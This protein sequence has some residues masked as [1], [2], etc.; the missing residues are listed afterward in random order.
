MLGYVLMQWS[1]VIAYAFHQLWAHECSY[2]THDLDL[3]T[4]VF[5]LK[6]WRQYLY[7]MH[8]DIYIDHQS[9]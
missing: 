8:W 9:L 5:V 7:G 6:V 4:M 1:R 3:A 2:P